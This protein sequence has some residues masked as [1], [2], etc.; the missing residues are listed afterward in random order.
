MRDVSDA[1]WKIMESG[2][3]GDTYHISTDDVVSIHELVERICAKLNVPFED[4]VEVVG[5][6][7]G[8]DSAYHLASTKLRNELGWQDRISLDQGLDECIAWVRT[9]FDALKAQ[10]SYDYIHKA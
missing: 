6:R 7:L 3:D 2:R 9:H 4:H 1:T 10:P 8:K 5:E